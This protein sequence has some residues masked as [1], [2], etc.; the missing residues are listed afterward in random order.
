MLEKYGMHNNYFKYSNYGV[1]RYIFTPNKLIDKNIPINS[2][3]FFSRSE[4]IN[5]INLIV[6]YALIEKLLKSVVTTYRID[7]SYL[8]TIMSLIN[9]SC[10]NLY[11]S[12]M[13]FVYRSII[14]EFEC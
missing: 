2:M 9:N 13:E 11:Y 12:D 3:Y 10:Y 4:T 7:E 6:K 14:K 8:K 1:I 5:Q